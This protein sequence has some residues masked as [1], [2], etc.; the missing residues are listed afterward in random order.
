VGEGKKAAWT[1]L[2]TESPGSVEPK[3]LRELQLELKAAK[4]E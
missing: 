4:K 3:Q 1:H 2:M